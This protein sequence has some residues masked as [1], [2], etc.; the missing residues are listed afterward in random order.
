VQC[1]IDSISPQTSGKQTSNRKK[2]TMKMKFRFD[3]GNVF[4]EFD[5]KPSEE[6][7]DAMK[8]N[9]FRWNPVEKHWWR[10]VYSGV[11]DFIA[12]LQKTLEPNKPDGKCWGC[13]EPGWFRNYG[14]ATPVYCDSCNE[15]FRKK[16]EARLSS[17]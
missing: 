11:A 8:A 4:L 1:S 13:G 7:R 9:R 12:Y 16:R 2:T 10:R 15:A 6:I 14:A 17:K 5:G 3:Y